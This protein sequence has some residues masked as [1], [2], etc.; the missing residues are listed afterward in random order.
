MATLEKLERAVMERLLDGDHPALAALRQQLPFLTVKSRRLTGVGFFTE[1]SLAEGVRAA[2]LVDPKIRFGD[3]EAS[4]DGLRHGAGFL[5]YI[6]NG[7]LQE[8]EGYTYDEPWPAE[9]G[10]FTLNYMDAKRKEVA[11]T[12]G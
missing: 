4:I 3:V 10:Q 7:L 1:F 12:F 5:L 2:T 11:K 8:L 6:D 9:I